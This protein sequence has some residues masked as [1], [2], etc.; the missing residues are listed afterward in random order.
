LIDNSALPT[1]GVTEWAGWSFTDPAWW[2]QAAG[3]QGR[4]Q[5]TKAS[6]VIA[7]AD[8]DEWD[9]L[10]HDAGTYNTFLKTPSI[11][12]TGTVPN[13]IQLRFDSSWLPEDFQTANLT[14][15]YSGGPAT[16]IMRW[17][18]EST[19]QDFKSAATNETVIIPLN[20]PT[21]ASSMVLEFGMLDAGNDWWWAIDNVQVFTPL[22]LNVNVDTGEASIISDPGL[23]ISGYEILSPQ[24]SLNA[25]GWL[26]GN[27]DHQDYDV[28]QLVGDFNID[29]AVNSLD[30][31]AWKSA[32]GQTAGADADGDGDSDGRDFLAWQRNFGS[33]TV[34]GEPWLTFLASNNQLI[35]AT[36]GSS[37]FATT[38]SLGLSYNTIKDA[39]DLTFRY[40]TSTG[41]ELDGVVLYTGGLNALTIP[42]PSLFKLLGGIVAQFLCSRMRT[43]LRSSLPRTTLKF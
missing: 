24:G 6:G 16:E 14:V 29:A 42:E 32:Y 19:S 9:D 25:N 40:I 36:L 26:A 27:L 8:P 31:N 41:E 22:T 34:A 37:E 28:P 18:S 7:V 15:S 43:R 21:G 30:L 20:N 4:T 2:A 13:T 1:G 39:R 35:E 3:D 12:L 23:E 10:P 17:S 5:F 11:S 33:Q 38:T